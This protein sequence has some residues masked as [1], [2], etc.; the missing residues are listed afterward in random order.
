MGEALGG[1]VAQVPEEEAERH[2]P[3]H[4]DDEGRPR[5]GARAVR[6]RLGESDPGEGTERPP[7]ED[8][9]GAPQLERGRLHS[10]LA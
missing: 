3:D 9:G 2:R 1:M 7:G 5:P 6:S 4:V 10:P 8:G